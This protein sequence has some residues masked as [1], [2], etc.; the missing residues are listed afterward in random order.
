MVRAAATSAWPM[1]WP[2]KTLRPPRSVDCP[3]NRFTSSC[4]RS[5]WRMR[6]CSVG[7]MRRLPPFGEE[8]RVR[9]D[10]AEMGRHFLSEARLQFGPVRGRQRQERERIGTPRVDG[11]PD[12]VLRPEQP[13]QGVEGDVPVFVP[14]H[15]RNLVALSLV[16][17]VER[18]SRLVVD[19]D[20][21][22][23]QIAG[24]EDVLGGADDRVV[25]L[26][27]VDEEDGLRI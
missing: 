23:R 14:G 13:V 27:P 11:D 17:E 26:A 9:L 22:G 4:S 1:T 12:L 16:R 15:E 2:P 6:P 18:E 20:E 24:L 5:S 10:L 19:A 7:S 3:R 21:L 25:F 8:I